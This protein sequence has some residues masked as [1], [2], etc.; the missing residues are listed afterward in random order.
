MSQ[1]HIV[2]VLQCHRVTLLQCHVNCLSLSSIDNLLTFPSRTLLW[3][4]VSGLETR[5]ECWSL[6]CL[7]E[8]CLFVQVDRTSAGGGG[9]GLGSRESHTL[10]LSSLLQCRGLCTASGETQERLTDKIYSHSRTYR[11][12]VQI[13]RVIPQLYED[14]YYKLSLSQL[15]EWPSTF[16]DCPLGTW[17]EHELSLSGSHH[18]SW[19]W[20]RCINCLLIPHRLLSIESKGAPPA[21][22]EKSAGPLSNGRTVIEIPHHTP[23]LVQTGDSTWH[24]TPATAIKC[25][26]FYFSRK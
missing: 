9:S 19:L 6:E 15:Y 1:C 18:L 13:F 14:S 3:G 8:M 23:P 11:Q 20:L 17:A 24:L 10:H 21:P 7:F 2:T 26:Y 25:L 16:P 5:A 4:P 22:S 12:P